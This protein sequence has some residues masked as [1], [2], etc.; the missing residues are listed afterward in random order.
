MIKPIQGGFGCRYLGAKMRFDGD[1][2]RISITLQCPELP[3]PVDITI[4]CKLG[5]TQ[6]IDY[7]IFKMDM[8]HQSLHVLVPI[9][10][11]GIAFKKGV[12]GIPVHTQA[13][14]VDQPDKLGSPLSGIRPK[15]SFIFDGKLQACRPGSLGCSQQAI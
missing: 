6:S 13:R 8:P 9:W 10:I 3:C 14:V 11:G 5:L 4:M 1:E 7:S 12:T 15:T 2:T